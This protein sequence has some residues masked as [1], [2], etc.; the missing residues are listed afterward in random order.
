MLTVLLKLTIFRQKVG[1]QAPLEIKVGEPRPMR[2]PGSATY[3]S[4][5]FS[6]L[7][8]PLSPG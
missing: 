5:P 1:G 2:P 4:S 3:G 7:R 6:P 8:R